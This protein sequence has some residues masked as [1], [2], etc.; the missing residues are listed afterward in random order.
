MLCAIARL[1]LSNRLPYLIPLPMVDLRMLIF[2]KDAPF[3]LGILATRNPGLNKV[4][5]KNIA[6]NPVDGPILKLHE[7]QLG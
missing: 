6:L 1:F 7:E 4:V 2:S 3:K 5:I